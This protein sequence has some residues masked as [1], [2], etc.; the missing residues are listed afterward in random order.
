MQCLLLIKALN[1][2][3]CCSNSYFDLLKL[4][5]DPCLAAAVVLL[6]PLAERVSAGRKKNNIKFSLFQFFKG[7]K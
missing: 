6:E 2:N 4:F 7:T 1:V 5:V 3:L